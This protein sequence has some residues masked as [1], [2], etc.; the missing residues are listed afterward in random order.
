MLHP[1]VCLAAHSAVQGIGIT[2]STLIRAGSVVWQMDN[3]DTIYSLQEIM[4]WTTDAREEFLKYAFQ[5][6]E[7]SFALCHDIDKYTNHSCEPNLWWSSDGTLTLVAR[8][9]IQPGEELTY[10]YVTSDILLDYRMEC[11]CGS[12]DCRGVITNKDYL[13][14]AWQQKYGVHLP[15]HVLKAIAEA[16]QSATHCLHSEREYY[17]DGENKDRT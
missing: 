11:N 8:N 3:N 6:G 13:D 5:C 2:T 9:D 4:T 16:R 12:A 15:P 17:A 14:A 1:G 7:Q 10:D